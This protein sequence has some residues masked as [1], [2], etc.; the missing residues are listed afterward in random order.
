MVCDAIDARTAYRVS[1]WDACSIVAAQRAGCEVLYP[2]DLHAGRS[3]GAVQV[4]N[5]LG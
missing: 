3:L 5:P 2:E 4:V 1:S